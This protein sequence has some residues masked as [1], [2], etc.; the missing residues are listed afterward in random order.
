MA[1]SDEAV[2][3]A[4]RLR[5]AL[6]AIEV[7]EEPLND[8]AEDAVEHEDFAARIE[9]IGVV[10]ERQKI[11]AEIISIEDGK[12]RVPGL[13]GEALFNSALSHYYGND[14]VTGQRILEQA[15]ELI[16]DIVSEG[17]AV[18]PDANESE[19]DEPGPN[20]PESIKE[21]I[22]KWMQRRMDSGA[23]DPLWQAYDQGTARQGHTDRGQNSDSKKSAKGKQKARET[24]PEN[25]VK[26]GGKRS[27][28][29][30]SSNESSPKQSSQKRAKTSKPS[31]AT[32]A[33]K[34]G[35]T[36]APAGPSN[37]TEM[38][39]APAGM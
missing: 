30:A 7:P 28:R 18:A 31:E 6:N 34:R 1:D 17:T 15:H 35:L 14:G 21:N 32:G 13:L 26:K 29:N 27:R 25:K 11:R 4:E 22:R 39:N 8:G 23:V 36:A 16:D 24:T 5:N 20:A 37:D 9:R 3:S 2:A 19:S 12:R 38:T 10:A 33:K